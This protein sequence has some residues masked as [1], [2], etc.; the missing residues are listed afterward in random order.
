MGQEFSVL[1]FGLIFDLGILIF[2]FH[3]SDLG[4]LALDV[5]FRIGILDA[6]GFLIFGC[7]AALGFDFFG[8]WISRF[9]FG[10]WVR[11]SGGYTMIRA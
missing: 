6:V 7:F 9:G 11:E 2:G 8:C 10:C 3:I 5:G 4:L 1:D